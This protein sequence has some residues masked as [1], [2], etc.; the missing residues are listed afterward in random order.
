MKLYLI[1]MPLSGKSVIGEL[2]ANA[3]NLGFLD[4]DTYIENKLSCSVYELVKSDESHF[5]HA[6]TDAL[7]DLIDKD[8]LVISTGGGIVLNRDNKQLM[9]GLIVYLDTPLDVLE[10]RLSKTYTR[11][12]LEKHSL[13]QLLEQRLPQYRY[14]QTFTIKTSTPEA[15]VQAIIETLKKENLL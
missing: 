8:D 13:K 11:P 15:T 5:R 7:I 1:G 2:L 9:R 4:L 3:L 6:E 10:S 14:F 12:L